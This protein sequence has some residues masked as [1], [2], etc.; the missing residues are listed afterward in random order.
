LV[1]EVFDKEDTP[2][3]VDRLQAAIAAVV[4]GA[5]AD[6]RQLETNAVG[7]PIQIQVS[8]GADT[9]PARSREEIARLRSLAER[10]TGILRSI[11]LATGV[12]D[13]WDEESFV[14]KV[15]VDSDRANLAGISNQDV[16]VSA[17]AGISGTQVAVLREGDRQIPI[18]ARLRPE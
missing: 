4:D 10:V 11:D 14:V 15:D 17:A 13:D 18:V 3:L 16:A 12:R 6:V 7:I 2:E 8:G 1:L 5:R 9:D